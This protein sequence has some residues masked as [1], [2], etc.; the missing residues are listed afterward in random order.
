MQNAAIRLNFRNSDP[1]SRLPRR[2]L[3]AGLFLCAGLSTSA[4]HAQTEVTYRWWNPNGSPETG[5]MNDSSNWE[6]FIKPSTSPNA[7]NRLAFRFVNEEH[8]EAINFL[9]DYLSVSAIDRV[10]SLNKIMRI[11]G[12]PLWLRTSIGD[13]KCVVH[14]GFLTG[15]TILETPLAG[16]TGMQ[17]LGDV[18]LNPSNQSQHT[19]TGG[20]EVDSGTLSISE[21]W[22]LGASSN[23]VTMTASNSQ[24]IF[25]DAM[26][27]AI[28]I[29]CERTGA[30]FHVLNGQSVTLQQYSGTGARAEKLGRGTLRV[31]STA[32]DNHWWVVEGALET[33]PGAIDD[34]TV[35]VNERRTLRLLGGS[36]ADFVESNGVVDVGEHTLELDAGEFRPGFEAAVIGSGVIR[37]AG[38]VSSRISFHTDLT[39]FDGVIES[40]GGKVVISD[41]ATLDSSVMLSAPQPQDLIEFMNARND[42][43]TY[44]I[45]GLSGAGD[46]TGNDLTQLII[47]VGNVDAFFSG[48]LTVGSLTKVGTGTQTLT[49]ANDLA[50]LPI[51]I[52]QG[53]LELS[54]PGI[55]GASSVNVDSDATFSSIGSVNVPIVTGAGTVK[56]NSGVLTVGE[57]GDDF[58]LSG[59]LTGFAADS[60]LRKRGTGTFTLSADTTGFGGF[61]QISD[62][63]VRFTGGPILPASA[64]LDISNGTLRGYGDLAVPFWNQGTIT[65]DSSAGVLRLAGQDQWNN[66]TIKAE[67]GG[68]LELNGVF[69]EQDF[70]GGL[71]HGRL[72][73]DETPIRMVGDNP[74]IVQGGTIETT[75]TGSL[76]L[77]GTAITLREVDH[78]GH[79]SLRSGVDVA[80]EDF[81]IVTTSEHTIEVEFEPDTDESDG[82]I[83]GHGTATLGGT[84]LVTLPDGYEPTA[85]DAMT[86]LGGDDTGEWTIDESFD[87]ID[88]PDVSP[89]IMR[90]ESNT[91]SLRLVV[92]CNADMAMPFG[93]LDFFD[94]SAFLA[95]YAS[96]DPSAD[97]DQNGLFDFFDVSAF[98]SQYSSGCS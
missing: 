28:P 2:A 45:G 68:T 60:T 58:T 84:L 85:G 98:L 3:A 36:A 37:S 73:S 52:P 19:I 79:L 87:S 38:P 56:L 5:S 6:D 66:G 76:E 71:Q 69:L 14:G 46:V 12:A 42:P 95:G 78:S 96:Q 48:S 57:P 29:I 24:I 77:I 23:T 65:A 30:R 49:G 18:T 41:S 75:G 89:L 59:T 34:G 33:G 27:V 62:G 39:D 55:G 44:R 54:G 53:T 74:T 86:V 51:M 1:Q 10:G 22:H 25:W 88:V 81:D 31:Y 72:E 82:A 90:V 80:A 4:A 15:E 20:I 91:D 50:G 13:N 94:I 26:S 64:R 70:S 83:R 97:F 47:G 63:A 17:I 67:N 8:F 7:R 61:F 43:V 93:L 35:S 40:R 11:S 21:P 9:R 16:T 32:S 92:T